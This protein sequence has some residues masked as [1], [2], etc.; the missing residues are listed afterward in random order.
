MGEDDP[1]S[2]L[3]LLYPGIQGVLGGIEFFLGLHEDIR[4]FEVLEFSTPGVLDIPNIAKK[5]D[6]V[7]NATFFYYLFRQR[8]DTELVS[9]FQNFL[10]LNRLGTFGRLV[11]RKK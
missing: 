4:G 2:A 8:N 10:Q 6:L 3:L 1:E 11:L 5:L 7:D 9:S